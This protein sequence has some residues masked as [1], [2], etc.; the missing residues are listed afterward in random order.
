[1]YTCMYIHTYVYTD[2]Y[3]N[4]YIYIHIIGADNI[5]DENEKKY[6]KNDDEDLLSSLRYVYVC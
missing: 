4:M 6:N 3:M 5:W 2:I 1:M